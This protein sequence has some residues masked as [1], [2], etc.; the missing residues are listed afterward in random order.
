MTLY[1]EIYFE[2]TCTGAKSE[3]KKLADFLK[4]GGLDDFF[5]FSRD[6]LSYD[7]SYSTAEDAAETSLTLSTDDYGIE[8]EEFDTGDFLDTFCRAAKALDVSGTLY[9]INDE[10]YNFKS[11][12]GDSYYLDKSKISFF[13]E[14]E[15]K[16]DEKDDEHE[17]D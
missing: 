3:I 16:E 1:D 12:A 2:I 5:E 4:A 8:I 11:D 9:D 17:E 15:D 10:E 14:D 7:D 6:Y 13:N